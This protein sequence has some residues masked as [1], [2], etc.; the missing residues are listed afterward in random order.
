M[1]GT[2]I[3]LCRS[4]LD[5]ALEAIRAALH[6]LHENSSAVAAVGVNEPS[7]EGD[8]DEGSKGADF[9]PP[10]FLVFFLRD[11]DSWSEHNHL[12]AVKWSQDVT[13]KGLAHVLLPTTSAVTPSAI[14]RL[15]NDQESAF[16]AVLI[17]IAKATVDS[18]TAEQK[19]LQLEVGLGSEWKQFE[20]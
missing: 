13:G 1:Y 19:L 14:Q 3:V 10:S 16:V 17:R 20:N 12:R 8:V 15:Q 7:S 18:T 4:E 5:M 2:E 6:E 11:I 9:A